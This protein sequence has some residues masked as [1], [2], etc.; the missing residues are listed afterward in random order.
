MTE[1]EHNKLRGKQ[2]ISRHDTHETLTDLYQI[3][4]GPEQTFTVDQRIESPWQ[5]PAFQNRYCS[6]YNHVGGVAYS[7]V[8]G[9]LSADPVDIPTDDLVMLPRKSREDSKAN[10]NLAYGITS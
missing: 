6:A 9:V 7:V 5:T 4:L 10:L 8:A 2:P 3:T 1:A